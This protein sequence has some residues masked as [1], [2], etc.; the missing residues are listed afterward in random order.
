MDSRADPCSDPGF[1]SGEEGPGPMAAHVTN[2]YVRACMHAYTR[3][4]THMHTHRH[5]NVHAQADG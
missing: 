3:T 4:H 5:V 2:T 1:S